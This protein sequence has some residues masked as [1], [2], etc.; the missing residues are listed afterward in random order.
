MARATWYVLEDGSTVDPSEVSM[1]EDGRLAHANGFVAMRSPDCPRSR[2]VDVDAS[3]K[4]L[5]GGKGDHDG[6]Q[7]VGGAKQPETVKEPEPEK[8]AEPP[9][10]T[11]PAKTTEMK[12]EPAPAPAQQP[13]YKRRGR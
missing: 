8:P 2:G 11:P 6:N 9:A 12:A 10:E 4:L 7:T 3:G 1:N 13:R 5:F